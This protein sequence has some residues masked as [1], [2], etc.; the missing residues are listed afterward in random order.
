MPQPSRV[1]E[2]PVIREGDNR[3]FNTTHKGSPGREIPIVQSDQ[4]ARQGYQQPPQAGFNP[5][6]AQDVGWGSQGRNSP[7][8]G[9]QVPIQRDNQPTQHPPQNWQWQPSSNQ[10]FQQNQQADYNQYAAGPQYTAGPQYS[11]SPRTAE[12]EYSHSPKQSQFSQGPQ[13][14]QG[15]KAREIPI[16]TEG[17][18]SPRTVRPPAGAASPPASKLAPEQPP[19][20]E[21]TPSPAPANLTPLQKVEGILAE[22]EALQAKVN[23][24]TGAKG[25]KGYLYV[26]EM[27]TRL[28]IKLDSVDSEGREEIRNCR[29]K[30]VRTVQASLDHLELRA[31]ANEPMDTNNSNATNQAMESDSGDKDSGIDDTGGHVN[32]MV[33]GSEINC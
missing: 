1:R 10:G 8:Q 11:H 24:F 32:E 9:R 7:S 26:E 28:M 22:A 30:A 31:M 12:P 17:S 20:K 21:Q 23:Q 2:I 16:E 3:R 14:S 19:P 33:L 4:P 27:L 13:Y 5:R 18:P 6:V 29:R 25:S 15:T